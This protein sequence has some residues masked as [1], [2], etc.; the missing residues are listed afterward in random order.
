[1]NEILTE[2]ETAAMLDCDPGTV[3]ALAREGKWPAV[4]VGRSWRF[5][6]QALIETLNNLGRMNMQRETVK[7]V[8][9][10]VRATRPVLV[11]L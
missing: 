7:P 3:Q 5:P 10:K 2:E 4:K 9:V 8:G 6:R 11:G 1:M